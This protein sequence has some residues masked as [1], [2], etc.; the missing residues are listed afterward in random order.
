MELAVVAG[1][2][3]ALALAAG[4]FQ[5]GRLRERVDVGQ[6]FEDRIG[7]VRTDIAEL[8]DRFDHWTKRERRRGHVE[9]V[10][11]EETNQPALPLAERRARLRERAAEMIGGRRGIR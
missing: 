5:V 4:A 3:V 8:H 9:R 2:L 1:A 6:E 7:V 11:A 10:E